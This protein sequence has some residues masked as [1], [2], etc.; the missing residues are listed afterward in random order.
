MLPVTEEDP[1][2]SCEWKG[3]TGGKGPSLRKV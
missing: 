1:L 3:C 2:A